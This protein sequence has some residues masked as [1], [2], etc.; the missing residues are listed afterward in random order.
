MKQIVLPLILASILLIIWQEAVSTPERQFLFSKP[1]L[2][3]RTFT[4]TTWSGEL[5][6]HALVT[7]SEA[8]LG[9]AIGVISGTLAGFMLWNF[10]LVRIAV[11][12]F[13]FILG[14]VP[15]IAFA[16]LV[17]V[18]FGIGFTMK[19]AL[20]SFAT[21]LIS[22]SQSCSGANHLKESDLKLLYVLGAT[23]FQVL[24]KAIIP[25]SLGW[26]FQSM[27]LNIGFALL[28]AFVG[29]F[30]SAEKGVGYYMMR[31]GSLYDLSAVFAGAIYIVILGIIFHLII[32]GIEKVGDRLL[33]WIS[34]SKEVR[35]A[36]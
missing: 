33:R 2:I 18:W 16:P 10:R 3:F 15:V 13:L 24:S 1:S 35:R 4:E 28:G 9:F 27:R 21:F 5:P 22:L 25:M 36:Q 14:V 6:A 26:V 30:I 8:I 7:G 23:R 34:I 17:L 32:V 11:Q 19:V 31:A 12:P 29:E 20:A